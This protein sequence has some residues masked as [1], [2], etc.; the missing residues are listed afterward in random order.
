MSSP[1]RYTSN[2]GRAFSDWSGMR[3]E[4]DERRG[5]SKDRS[6]KRGRVEEEREEGV[7]EQLLYHNKRR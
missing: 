3:K 5:K 6:E 2:A 7:R 4:K 1:P